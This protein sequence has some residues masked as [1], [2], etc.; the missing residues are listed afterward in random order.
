MKTPSKEDKQVIRDEAD[1]TDR[2]GKRQ[3]GIEKE[4][5][6]RAVL[7]A[8]D[9]AEKEPTASTAAKTFI[10]KLRHFLGF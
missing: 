7:L 6:M 8:H 5:A 10:R 9:A 2:E 4:R 3:A 1:A